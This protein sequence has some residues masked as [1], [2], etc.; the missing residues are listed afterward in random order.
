METKTAISMN[1][2]PCVFCYTA[3]SKNGEWIITGAIKD[4]KLKIGDVLCDIPYNGINGHYF[5]ILK[6]DYRKHRGNTDREH[7]TATCEFIS[8]ED[9]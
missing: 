3:K 2:N 1:Q 9:F 7:F 4:D 6:I 5:K 8:K